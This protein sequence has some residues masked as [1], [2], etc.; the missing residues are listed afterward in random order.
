MGAG[1]PGTL[2]ETMRELSSAQPLAG[3]HIFGECGVTPHSP[4]MCLPANGWAEES[5]RIVSVKVPGEPAPIP[6]NRYIVE[7]DG[8]RKLVLY[9]FQN[10]RRATADEY[11]SK[12]YLIY[13]SIRYRRSDEALIRDRKSTRL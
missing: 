5:S 6:V 9:W 3:R 2:T 10:W 1:S 11:L 13:D 8:Q 7:K 4:K 12:V